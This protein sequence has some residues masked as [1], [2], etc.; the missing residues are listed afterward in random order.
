MKIVTDP[1]IPLPRRGITD[2]VQVRGYSRTDRQ[3]GRE[4]S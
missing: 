4:S 3:K 1:Y 2:E